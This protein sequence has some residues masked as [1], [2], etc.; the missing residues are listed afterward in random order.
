MHEGKK[1]LVSVKLKWEE[2]ITIY[3]KDTG[4]KE[5]NSICLAQRV[6]VSRQYGGDSCKVSDY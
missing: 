1:Y 3:L 5:V 2:K 6:A 4:Y